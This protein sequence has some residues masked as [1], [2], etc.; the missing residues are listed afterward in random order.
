M[1]PSDGVRGRRLVRAARR[2]DRG[3][4]ERLVV[5]HLDLVRAVACRYRGLGL[6][7]DDLVQEGSLGLL[8]DV[9]RYDP[10]RSPD[11]ESYARFRVRRAI[12][13]ALTE[14]TRLVRLPKHVVER[15]RA[16]ARAAAELEAANGREPTTAELAL[17]TGLIAGAVEEARAVRAQPVLDGDAALGAADPAPADLEHRL[18]SEDEARRLRAAVARLPA[19]QRYVIT[20]R[21]GLDGDPARVAELAAALHVSQRRTRTIEHDALHELARV[22]E[23]SAGHGSL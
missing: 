13:N 5:A 6:P 22:L 19:R 16:L 15:R 8:D 17:R 12:R 7:F 23:R 10:S 20:R 11:F 3:A 1:A 4:R 14:Q 9:D 21:Y 18:V 2:G